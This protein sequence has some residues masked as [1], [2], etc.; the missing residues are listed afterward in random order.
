MTMRWDPTLGE[1][2]LPAAGAPGAIMGDFDY[3]AITPSAR[4]A[5]ALQTAFPHAA[6]RPGL[7]RALN[8]ASPFLYSDYLMGIQPETMTAGSTVEAPTFGQWLLG[9]QQHM[10]A[11]GATGTAPLFGGAYGG[12]ET[13]VPAGTYGLGATRWGQLQGGPRGQYVPEGWADMIN[14]ARQ[15]GTTGAGFTPT[16][17][18]RDVYDRYSDVLSMQGAPEAFTQIATAADPRMAG[19]AV[20][21]MRA[22]AMERERERWD[23]MRGGTG[24]AADWLGYITGPSGLAGQGYQV[25]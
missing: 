3:G 4:Y 10:P 24:T 6:Q 5:M 17:M 18:D 8:R 13:G 2:T 12:G 21:G 14:V 23:I 25:T 15:M 22:R 7:A 16:G 9:R 20:A 19:S 11:L 1:F